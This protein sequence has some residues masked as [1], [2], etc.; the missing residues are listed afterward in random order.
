MSSSGSQSVLNIKQIPCRLLLPPDK[1][2]QHHSPNYMQDECIHNQQNKVNLLVPTSHCRVWD[3]VFR[4]TQFPWF[5]VGPSPKTCISPKRPSF[6][7]VE[8][9]S[10]S[11]HINLQTPWKKHSSTHTP[12]GK[13][14]SSQTHTELGFIHD[15]TRHSQNYSD[16]CNNDSF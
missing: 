10:G 6:T 4:K 14:K 16:K 13:S 7:R 9:E 2:W 11:N 3:T 1:T 5:P 12:S 15:N 8:H